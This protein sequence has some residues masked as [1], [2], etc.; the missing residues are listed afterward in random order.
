LSVD[1]GGSNCHYPGSQHGVGFSTQSGAYKSLLSVAVVPGDA[2]GSIFY[3]D[4]ASG[5]M[6]DG[7]PMLSS[8]FIDKIGAWIDAGALNN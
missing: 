2:Q 7:K 1:C 3:L 4:V 8:V 6:P 5:A